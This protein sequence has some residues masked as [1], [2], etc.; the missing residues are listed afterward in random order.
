MLSASILLVLR[1]CSHPDRA[2]TVTV[3]FFDQQP[4]VSVPRQNINFNVKYNDDKTLIYI[5]NTVSNPDILYFYI[6][7]E[8]SLWKTNIII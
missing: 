7:F 6:L 3:L 1:Y 2:L 5:F 8:V 4:A